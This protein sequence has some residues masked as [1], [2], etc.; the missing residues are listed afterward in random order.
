MRV[1]RYGH[2][3]VP[4]VVWGP[5]GSVDR[6]IVAVGG[7]SADAGRLSSVEEYS[8]YHERWKRSG[9]VGRTQWVWLCVCAWLAAVCSVA[10]SLVI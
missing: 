10:A 8:C 9:A 1:P 6:R 5:A 7:Y 2:A 3:A 4:M